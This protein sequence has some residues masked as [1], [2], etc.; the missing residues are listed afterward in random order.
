MQQKLNLKIKFREAFRP[1][2]PSVLAEDCERILIMIWISLYA[3]CRS[4]KKT[5][6]SDC[7][8]NLIHFLSEDNYILSALICR[9]NHIRTFPPGSKLYT[10]KPILFWE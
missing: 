2:A 10:K 7:Q 9:H 5:D 8:E 6:R 4:V 3:N 1:F